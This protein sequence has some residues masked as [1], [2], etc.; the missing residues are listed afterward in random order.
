MPSWHSLGSFEKITSFTWHRSMSKFRL[1]LINDTD[2]IPVAGLGLDLWPQ[3][4]LQ[5]VSWGFLGKVAF[6]LNGDTI[7]GMTL[8]SFWMLP[9]LNRLCEVTATPVLPEPEE[10][11]RKAK[12]LGSWGC[13]LTPLTSS[14]GGLLI[15]Q[16]STFPYCWSYSKFN[17]FLAAKRTLTNCPTN[18]HS[19]LLT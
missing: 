3:L 12:K 2:P 13:D 17:L 9:R 14:R 15:M 6:L 19:S 8:F 1:L 10:Q 16:D 4:W 7:E 18:D 5:E 11:S